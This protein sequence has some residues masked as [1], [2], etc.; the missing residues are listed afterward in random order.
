VRALAVTSLRRIDAMPDLPTMAE[1]GFPG[2]E[3]TG[4]TGLFLPRGAAD[5]VVRALNK[6]FR[7]ATET[8]VARE[9]AK[10]SGA[11]YA[12]GTPEELA[13]WVKSEIEK[14][15]LIVKLAGI[16]PE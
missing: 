10:N 11:Y 1:S 5:D 14:W 7:D 13:A 4:W 2:F 16:Q 9:F 15:A 6:A 3:M 8:D 12:T